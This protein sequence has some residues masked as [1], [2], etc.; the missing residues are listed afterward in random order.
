M[1]LPFLVTAMAFSINLFAKPKAEVAI[2]LDTS[3]SMQGLINQ[4]RDGLWDT[5]N[6]LGEIKKNGEVADLKLALYEYGSGVVSAEAN[7][8]QMLVPLTTDHMVVAEKLFATQAK[9]SEEYSGMAIDMA[10]KDLAFSSSMDDFK[11]ILLAGNET[12]YQGPVEPLVASKAAL[13]HGILVNTIYAGSQTKPVYNPLP[14]GG[15]HH[16]G[17]TCRNWSCTALG[18]APLVSSSTDTETELNPEY[19]EYKLLASAG[20]GMTLNIDHQNSIPH[21]ESPYDQE[22][23]KVTEAI[24]ETYL[25]YGSNGQS[26]Y[27]RMRNLDRS[28]RGAG[29]GSYIG[30]GGYRSGS[31]G[32]ST[33]SS[34]DLVSAYRKETLDLASI[35][36]KY[37]PKKLQGLSDF[38]KLEL[39]KEM[40]S[41]R[42]QLE[43]EVSELKLKRKQYV[44]AKL[45]AMPEGSN[46]QADFAKAMKAILLKQ[47]KSKGFEVIAK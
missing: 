46:P 45:E 41:K 43:T 26:E 11:S 37:L 44:Q 33:I 47:L 22:I 7:Y 10:T 30:W 29:D 34:W 25:P 20:G 36:E 15:G 8:I 14:R 4:V 42:Q 19:A 39:I 17:G 35:K 18:H 31:Y 27:T 24:T 23:I 9:G 28:V 2:L 5:L 12:I 21:I 3:G 13:D 38:E 6:N 32:E 40:S 1:K 16:G